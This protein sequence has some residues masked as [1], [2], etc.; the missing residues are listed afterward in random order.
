MN[1][2]IRILF[3]AIIGFAIVVLIM[4]NRDKYT[5]NEAESIIYKA[6]AEHKLEVSPKHIIYVHIDTLKKYQYIWDAAEQLEV[7]Y[8]SYEVRIEGM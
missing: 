5:K 6:N 7:E 8:Q 1:S 3:G 4:L 2:F